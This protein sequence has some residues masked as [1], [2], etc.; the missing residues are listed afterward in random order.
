MLSKKEINRQ[1]RKLWG[2]LMSANNEVRYCVKTYGSA[3]VYDVTDGKKSQLV[4]VG[5]PSQIN[6]NNLA[7]LGFNIQNT[8]V[9]FFMVVTSNHDIKY[10]NERR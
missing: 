7:Q 9:N 3:F 2:L 1:K 10:W 4:T 5:L 6:D 8:T